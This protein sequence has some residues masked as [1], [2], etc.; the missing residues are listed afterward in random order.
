MAG[1]AGKDRRR[2]LPFPPMWERDGQAHER[3]EHGPQAQGCLDAR[4]LGYLGVSWA[5]PSLPA[6]W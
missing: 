1:V 3:Q 2:K 6:C 4:V 5:R